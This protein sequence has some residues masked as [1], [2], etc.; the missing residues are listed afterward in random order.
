MS[1]RKVAAVLL[2]VGLFV[3][4]V[5]AA[6]NTVPATKMGLVTDTLTASKLAPSACSALLLSGVVAGDGDL[7]SGGINELFLGGPGPQLI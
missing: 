5:Q 3:G 1:A 7:A 4:I 6:A 2:A